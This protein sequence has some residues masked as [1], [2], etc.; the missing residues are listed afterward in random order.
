[1]DFAINI[2]KLADKLKQ[3]HQQELASQ[4]VRSGTSIGANIAESEYAVSKA[5]FINKLQISLK[6]VNETKYWLH[7]LYK[8]KKIIDTEYFKLNDDILEIM[9]IL[10]SSLNSS[11]KQLN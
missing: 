4:I 3:N 11:K 5:D 9:K 2:V 7:V 6:E 10:I 1:M 8:S